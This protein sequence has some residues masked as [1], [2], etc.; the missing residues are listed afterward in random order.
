MALE[1]VIESFSLMFSGAMGGL[2]HSMTRKQG[3]R[4][5]CVSVFVGAI[6]AYFLA[7]LGVY[8]LEYLIP[9]AVGAN[10]YSIAGFLIGILG[11]DLTQTIIRWFESRSKK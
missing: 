7:P 9:N 1:N 2:V 6:C 10:L 3:F 11:L 4:D 8:Y 5:S